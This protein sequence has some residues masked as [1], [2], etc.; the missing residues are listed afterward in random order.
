MLK[1][2]III[3]YASNKGEVFSES[4]HLRLLNKAKD[5]GILG[6]T[7][8]KPS[9]QLVGFWYNPK[10]SILYQEPNGYF[11]TSGTAKIKNKIKKL[12]EFA[13]ELY[14]QDSIYTEAIQTDVNFI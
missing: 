2:T 3:P 4:Y 5:L 12:A 11:T 8:F 6:G 1:Y 14:Q 13:K 10:N 7:F 9:S